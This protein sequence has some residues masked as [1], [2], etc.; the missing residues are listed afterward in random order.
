MNNEIQKHLDIMLEYI[1]NFQPFIENR[2]QDENGLYF[3][4]FHHGEGEQTS[5]INTSIKNEVL[6]LLRSQ[7][8]INLEGRKNFIGLEGLWT[9][10][11][12]EILK[13]EGFLKQQI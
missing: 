9:K 6:G 13:F 5:Y 3:G 8:T 12:Q 10:E 11:P 7:S 1:P 4:I 2:E